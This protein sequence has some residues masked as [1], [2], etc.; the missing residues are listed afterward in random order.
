MKSINSHSCENGTLLSMWTWI[1]AGL[2]STRL[3]SQEEHL[4]PAILIYAAGR[5]STAYFMNTAMNT[6]PSLSKSFTI[7]FSKSC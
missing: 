4:W 1:N 2:S 7:V 6:R 3:S 5:F